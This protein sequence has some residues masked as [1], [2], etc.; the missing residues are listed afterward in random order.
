MSTTPA[1]PA[2]PS[3]PFLLTLVS[4]TGGL[5]SVAP[6]AGADDPPAW[7]EQSVLRGHAKEIAALAFAPDGKG[8]A[9]ASHDGTVK[10]WDAAAAKARFSVKAHRG[11]VVTLAYAGDGK[12]LVSVGGDGFVRRWDV[13]TGRQRSGVRLALRDTVIAAK[14]SP[15]GKA[16]VTTA[17]NLVERRLPGEVQLWDLATGRKRSRF[18]THEMG[19]YHLA[20]SPDGKTLATTGEKLEIMPMATGPCVTLVEVKLWDLSTGKERDTLT[21]CGSAVF[22]PDGKTLAALAAEG[23]PDKP[24]GV[25]RLW[26][27]AGRKEV[28]VLRGHTGPITALALSPDGRTLATAGGD[29]TVRLWDVAAR[30]ERALLKGHTGAVSCL[31]FSADGDTLASAGADRMVRLWVAD[32]R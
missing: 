8:L 12:A 17:G 7:K 22:T 25:V 29:G 24:V 18:A 23:K 31:A 9:S 10:L 2:A 3:W 14:V 28:A 21:K 11:P 19:P 20:F 27:V 6:A 32:K 26:D 13:A 15:D 16:L 1:C 5:L 4:L 30:K